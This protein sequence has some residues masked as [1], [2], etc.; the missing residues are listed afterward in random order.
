MKVVADSHT[1]VRYLVDPGRLSEPALKIL[2]EAEDTD[3][4]IISAATPGRPLVCRHPAEGS[5]GP[6]R[7][8]HP[9][10]RSTARYTPRDGRPS[11]LQDRDSQD[12][13]VGEAPHRCFN[14]RQV[15]LQTDGPTWCVDRVTAFRHIGNILAV[16]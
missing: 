15:A 16:S 3:G 2:L 13:L 14:R 10:H 5:P 7:P 6:V 4:V 12:R 9:G 11:D 1:L 8:I